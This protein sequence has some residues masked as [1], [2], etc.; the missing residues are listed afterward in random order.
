[1][2]EMG[3]PL[4][5]L[6]INGTASAINAKIKTIKEERNIKK[7]RAIYNEKRL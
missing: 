1:M 2:I 7:V 4:T 3:T 5:T 6:A